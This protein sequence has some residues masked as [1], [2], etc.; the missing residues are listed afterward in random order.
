MEDGSWVLLSDEDLAAAAPR[1]SHT[2]DIEAF[3]EE[4]EI[5]PI[6][7]DRPYLLVPRTRARR[8]PMPCLA[9]RWATRARWRLGA[10]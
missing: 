5:D 6:Y 1:K 8:G 7:L 2:I 9:R 3:I 4:R 10:L